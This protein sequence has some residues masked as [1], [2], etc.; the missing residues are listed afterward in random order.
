[1][2]FDQLDQLLQNLHQKLALPANHLRTPPKN[3]WSVRVASEFAQYSIFDPRLAVNI[4]AINRRQ[5]QS[6]C[7]PIHLILPLRLQIVGLVL[8]RGQSQIL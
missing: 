5:I 3:R 7:R 6:L 4:Q 2:L 1:M 8:S